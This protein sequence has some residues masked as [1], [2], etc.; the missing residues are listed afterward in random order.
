M[1]AMDFAG[2]QIGGRLRN[3]HEGLL[4]SGAFPLSLTPP[5]SLSLALSLS[6]SRSIYL[7]QALSFS[8]HLSRSLALSLALFLSFS[9]TLFL[10]RARTSSFPPIF[11]RSLILSHPLTPLSL[12]LS[13]PPPPYNLCGGWSCY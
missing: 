4:P 6:L 1:Q 5:L 11:W 10:S 7:S 13:A 8:L 2:A 12:S 9:I 3:V